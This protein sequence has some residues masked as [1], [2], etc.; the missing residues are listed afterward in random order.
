MIS[1]ARQVNNMKPQEPG[2]FFRAIRIACLLVVMSSL[3]T[4][5]IVAQDEE[6][7][8]IVNRVDSEAFPEVTVYLTAIGPTGLPPSEAEFRILEDGTPLADDAALTATP[9]TEQPIS[10]VIALDISLPDETLGRLQANLKAFVAGLQPA[11]KVALLVFHDDV[12]TVSEFST[13]KAALQTSLDSLTRT[14]NSTAFN[15]G[16]I[17]GVDMAQALLSGPKGIIAIT[18]RANN[19]GEVTVDDAID[20]AQ[21]TGI[22]IFP[23]GLGDVIQLADINALARSTGGQAFIQPDMQPTLEEIASQMRQG[24]KLTFLSGLEADDGPHEMVIQAD[25]AEGTGTATSSFVANSGDVSVSLPGLSENQSVGGQVLL[26]VEVESPAPVATVDYQLDGVTIASVTEPP[27]NLEWDST[28]ISPGQHLLTIRAIDTAGNE[29]QTSLNLSVV[30]PVEVTIS[31]A[32][33][34]VELGE[35][36]PLGANIQ[37]LTAVQMVELLLDGEVVQSD[38]QPPF[39]L[40]LD[41]GQFTA[42]RHTIMVRV[43]DSQGNVAQAS[44]TLEFLAPSVPTPLPTPLPTPAPQPA[45]PSG[46]PRALVIAVLLVALI[47]LVFGLLFLLLYIPKAQRRK[48]RRSFKLQIANLGNA[49][50]R[51][52]LRATDPGQ[53]LKFQFMLD[54][55]SLHLQQQP[56]AVEAAQQTVNGPLAPTPIATPPPADQQQVAS[57]AGSPPSPQVEKPGL[58]T[59]L[60]GALRLGGIIAT[61]LSTLSYLLPRSMAA[62]LMQASYKLRSGEVAAMRAQQVSS[63]VG[64]LGPARGGAAPGSG[65]QSYSP[66]SASQPQVALQPQAGPQP[67]AGGQAV[68]Q[69]QVGRQQAAASEA[70]VL[71]DAQTPFI[72]PGETLAVDLL[73]D[74]VKPFDAQYYPFTINSISLEQTEREPV[75][76]Q[77]SV[78][79]QGLAWYRRYLLPILATIIGT[80]IIF[81]IGLFLMIYVGSGGS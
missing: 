14:G 55:F 10:L 60:G 52:E 17:E 12:V 37:A 33:E 34:A 1:S 6:A 3:V 80:G 64:S 66:Q 58:M 29:G 25:Y 26:Q 73:I 35:S 27:F 18:D 19:I 77:G 61:I 2:R 46:L 45:A 76:E 15:E 57:F 67:Q 22:R 50:S 32:P 54:G 38:S 59:R 75:V 49:R 7:I 41:S 11:D 39:D 43:T 20:A 81:S 78:R 23:I 28:V 65:S 71:S 21:E 44:T 24:Y 5:Q 4:G 51:Y 69:P 79:I 74:P 48:S 70:V 31:N 68:P 62:P 56:Q 63:Q 13:D 47:A 36:V 42:G 30:A 53:V 8:I 40:S 9:D 72:E 16:V